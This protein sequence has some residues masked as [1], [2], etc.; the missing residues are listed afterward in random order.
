MLTRC[1][2]A[3]CREELVQ[4]TGADIGD[5]VAELIQAHLD[6]LAEG[7]GDDHPLPRVGGIIDEQLRASAVALPTERCDVT[8]LC[9]LSHECDPFRLTVQRLC[10][11][12][13]PTATSLE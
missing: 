3:R 6:A 7:I 9:R 10:L 4:Y 5:Q 12:P 11:D 13:D 2:S 8:Q 1:R